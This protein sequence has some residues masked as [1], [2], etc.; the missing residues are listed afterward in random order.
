[1]ARIEVAP[2]AKVD[3][4]DVTHHLRRQARGGTVDKLEAEVADAFRCLVDHPEMG[5][6]RLEIGAGL[7]SITVWPYVILYR[8]DR[9]R[10]TILVLR[11]LHG[12]RRL[13]LDAP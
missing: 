3:L 4:A 9:A 1:M 8:Y 2:S 13:A 7:R 12:R 6:R 5:R 11:V 10:D